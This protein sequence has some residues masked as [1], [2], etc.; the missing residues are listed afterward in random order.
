[1]GDGH[2]NLFLSFSFHRH[3][4]DPFLRCHGAIVRWAS[5]AIEA[6]S[7]REEPI[8]WVKLVFIKDELEWRWRF[9]SLERSEGRIDLCF[10]EFEAEDW[11]T[12]AGSGRTD[13]SAALILPQ[14]QLN[15]MRTAVA[16]YTPDW[17]IR[18][19]WCMGF[20]SEQF[21]FPASRD[22]SANR[23]VAPWVKR[24]TVESVEL[25]LVQICCERIEPA[26]AAELVDQYWAA[27][28]K[29]AYSTILQT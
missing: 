6:H 10:R 26:K 4:L 16:R 22:I 19:N 21:A 28:R 5:S 23:S 13:I 1:M 7:H 3:T 9:P 25:T 24:L 27:P 2:R 11:R 14:R 12:R 20:R 18:L 8:R 17:D 15:E 29:I